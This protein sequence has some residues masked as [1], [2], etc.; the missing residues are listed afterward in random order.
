MGIVAGSLFALA[1]AAAPQPVAVAPDVT[2][3]RGEF[4]PNRQPDGNTVVIDAPDGLVVFDTGRHKAHAQAIADLAKARGK[5]VAA[6]V[7][8]HWH[9]DHVGGNI[10]LRAAFPR[11]KVY[12]T[13]AIDAALGGFLASYRR[14]LAQ[15]IDQA[16]SDPKAQES[17]RAELAL[18]DA[19][20]R[21]QP[22]ERIAQSG[23]RPIAGRRFELTV[24]AP[25]VTH[26]DL[27][28]F[29]PATRTL[30]AG[31]LV[32]LP[33]P[34]FDTACPARWSAA[35]ADLDR[36][37][38][39]LLVPGHGAPMPHASLTQYRRAFDALVACAASEREA[40]ACVDG[41]IADAGSL[42]PEPER[43]FARSLVDYYVA[44]VLRG[45]AKRLEANCATSGNVH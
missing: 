1:F 12:A 5:P 27:T 7:N 6:I 9:L 14:Q 3:I 23:L 25:A 13:G 38:F 34:L 45:D 26:G 40:S 19:G 30:M 32:T 2:L 31:D 4:V 24:V 39:K 42:V 28:L 41:W 10:A 36:A 35:L 15:A 11:A 33:A 18:I 21:L 20:E 43:K 17:Y 44:N 29:D 16:A 8:S 22:T 37:D